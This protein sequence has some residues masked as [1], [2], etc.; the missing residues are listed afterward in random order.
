MAVLVSCFVLPGLAELLEI[1]ETD[2]AILLLMP[3]PLAS[4]IVSPHD[5]PV[6]LLARGVQWRVVLVD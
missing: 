1:R 2:V 5:G 3:S 4:G 6:V